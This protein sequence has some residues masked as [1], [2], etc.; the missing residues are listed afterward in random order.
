MVEPRRTF[1][2]GKPITR[3]TAGASGTASVTFLKKLVLTMASASGSGS[4][5]VGAPSVASSSLVRNTVL[6]PSRSHAWMV[7][8]TSMNSLPPASQVTT[9]P[10]APSCLA[11]LAVWLAISCFSCC[12]VHSVRSAITPRK[13]QSRPWRRYRSSRSG[14]LATVHD[15][16]KAV[17]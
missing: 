9:A 4:S 15:M 10:C 5:M 17:R 6:M 8:T 14:L 7:R 3:D 1:L 13:F 11:S 12:V 16:A 2:V